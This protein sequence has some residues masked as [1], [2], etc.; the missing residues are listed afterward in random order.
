MLLVYEYEA[1]ITFTTGHILFDDVYLN[2][3]KFHGIMTDMGSYGYMESCLIIMIATYMLRFIA[4]VVCK[5]FNL[6]ENSNS[7]FK[8]YELRMN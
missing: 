6:F 5:H 2:F 7:K 4:C 8:T 3:A 1:L